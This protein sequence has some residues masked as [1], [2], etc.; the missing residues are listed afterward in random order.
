MPPRG[1]PDVHR[2]DEGAERRDDDVQP[3]REI[4]NGRAGKRYAAAHSLDYPF[5]GGVHDATYGEP[6]EVTITGSTL[7]VDN[8]LVS[9][10]SYPLGRRLLGVRGRNNVPVRV[11]LDDDG[12]AS[13]VSEQYRP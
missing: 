12:R 6:I 10:T 1:A 13:Q 9:G 2:H 7:C 4:L 5:P 3:F 8:M 11:R